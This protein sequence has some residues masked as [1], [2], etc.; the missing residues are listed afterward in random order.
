MGDGKKANRFEAVVVYCNESE[1][2]AMSDYLV[3]FE[4]CPV[5]VFVGDCKP[6]GGFVLSKCMPPS[7]PAAITTS[8]KS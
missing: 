2:T 3:R 1:Y 5:V 8:I 6:S 7:D 4:D